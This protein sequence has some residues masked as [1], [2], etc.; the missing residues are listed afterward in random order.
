M[1]AIEDEYTAEK[2][3]VLRKFA[4]KLF[5]KEAE[6]IKKQELIE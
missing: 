1:K 5:E 4:M 3:I 6:K 2:L